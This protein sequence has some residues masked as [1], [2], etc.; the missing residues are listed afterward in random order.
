MN[1]LAERFIAYQ[2][3]ARL[4]QPVLADGKVSRATGLVIEAT[5]RQGTVGDICDIITSSRQAIR[6]EIVG[7][8]DKRLLLMP[9]GETVG[10]APGNRVTLRPEP[11]QVPVGDN[12]LGRVL[13]GLG[14][15]IDGKPDIHSRHYRP[16]YNTPPNPLVRMVIKERLET[17]I[18]AID[19]LITLGKGQRAGIFAGSGVGK[20]VLLG[21]IA[22]NSDTD[23]AVICLIGERGR[24]VREFI[25]RDLGEDGL[26]RS[27]VVV[28]TSDQPATVRIKSALI[29][30]TIAEYFRDQGKNVLLMM[31][32]LTRV[33]M[34]QREIGL[35]IG[36][37]PASKGY[38]PSV[39]ALLPRLLERAGNSDVGSITG[40]YT[41]LVDGDDMDE[42]IADAARSILDGH[43]VLSRKIAHRGHFPAIDVLESVS[44]VK[45]EVMPDNQKKMSLKILNQMAVYRESED[46]INIGA[47]S[48]GS[49]KEIDAAIDNINNINAFL[50]QGIGEAS[51][52]FQMLEQL[53]KVAQG[54]G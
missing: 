9:L 32:S 11:L 31:D 10:V 21:M 26:R 47:Y 24:E 30:T 48:R 34:A 53:E 16:V 4:V 3:K 12:L 22:K 45:N 46:L 35:A 2:K 23:V 44:R 39:F 6:S 51:N 19:G 18:R 8:R 1:E 13:N 37:P 41:V 17:S 52:Y 54:A 36:E 49:S 20:S 7:F 29:A 15:P 42:P 28:A 27:V 25:E 33:A 40:L 38:T 14:Q 50:R 43:I 5:A